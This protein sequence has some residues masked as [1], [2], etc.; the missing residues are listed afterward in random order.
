MKARVKALGYIGCSV[1]SLDAWD[2]FLASLFALEGRSDSSGAV[3][4][5][6][7]DGHC[8][9]LT[10]RQAQHDSLSYVGWEVASPEDLQQL[11]RHLAMN[12][13][14]CKRGDRA[15]CAE[16]G[17]TDLLVLVGPD[18]VCTELFCG[19]S[20]GSEPSAAG[21]AGALRLG[22]IVL[23]SADRGASVDWYRKV[24]GF[25]VSD[26]IFWDGVEASF[27]RCNSRHHS[28][29]LT[30]PVGDMHGGDLGHFMFEADSMD[31]VG[32]AYDVVRQCG[33]PIA[34]TLG[35]HSNDDAFSFYV[36][37]PSGWLVEYGYGGRI[38]DDPAWETRIYDAPSIWGHEMQPPPGGDQ[39][40]KRY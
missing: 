35:R 11:E 13:I 36:Y 2:E 37:A 28:L 32:R 24:F 22:H 5:F 38:I 30:N 19:P 27:L 8:R 10:L 18:G 7:I 4:H 14:A 23:A 34:F 21:V 26:H 17:V 39:Q 25:S 12:G 16:R 31:E 20:M 1:S 40:K 33:I 9:R 3:R 6:D 29:A 15:L